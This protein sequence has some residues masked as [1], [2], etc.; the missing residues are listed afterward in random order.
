MGLAEGLLIV[1]IVCVFAYFVLRPDRFGR[2]SRG[3][4]DSGSG[5]SGIGGYYGGDSDHHSHDL[6]SDTGGDGGGDAGGDGGGDGGG[7]GD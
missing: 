5:D 4:G 7:G 6:T 3:S 1:A 2:A